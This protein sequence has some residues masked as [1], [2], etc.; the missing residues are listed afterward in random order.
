MCGAHTNAKYKYGRYP[1]SGRDATSALFRA[2]HSDVRS[3][4]LN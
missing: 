1:I 4:A 2:Y 3:E